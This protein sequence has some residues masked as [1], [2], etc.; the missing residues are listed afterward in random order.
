MKEGR[1]GEGGQA[2]AVDSAARRD[3][4]CR[5]MKILVIG[6][7]G[8]EHALCWKLKQSPKVEQIWCA[9]GNGGIELD[10]ECVPAD[11]KD[12]AAL[13]S[14]AEQLRP[15]LTMV[16]PEQPL[17]DGIVDRFEERGLAIVGPKKQAAQLE[18]SK[19]FAKQFMKKHGI[20]MAG[21]YGIYD[22][23][24][25]AYSALCAV[26]WPMVIKADGLCGGKGVLVAPTPDEAT[27]F[28]ERLM[29]NDEFGP[30]GR[31]VVLEEALEGEELSYIVLTDGKTVIPMAPTRDHKRALDGDL[32]PNTG[33]MGAYSTEGMISPALDQQIRSTILEPTIRGLAADG[34][35]YRGFLYFGLMLTAN[36]PKV[37]EYNCRL[38]DPETQA[39]VMRMDFDLSNA[40]MA[41][42]R[43]EL[44]KVIPVWAPAASACIVLASCG[45]PGEFEK[46]KA[47]AGLE[48][49]ADS[50]TK[51]FHA[52]TR[53]EGSIYYTNSGR[54]LGVAANGATSEAALEKAYEATGK[55]HF[56]GMQYRRDIG[57]VMKQQ[58][59]A[60]GN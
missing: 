42:A 4:L 56:D 15:D 26:D 17:V 32:G 11:T 18:G 25:D 51:V 47:I 37:L 31:R 6:S 48:G 59:S 35:P 52:G 3:Y 8:R 49:G 46:G 1:D 19:V 43:G 53:C 10:A 44:D 22:S 12:V 57:A 27:A 29:E 41:T 60:A 33:G 36:G 20:P 7:G 5:T 38:G 30:A 34:M 24:G 54:A 45:Y 9:P 16:G 55:I 28:I 14:L 40:L 21:L 58:S 13:V 2:L 39:L 23:P 50:T